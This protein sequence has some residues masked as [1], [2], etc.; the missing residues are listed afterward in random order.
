MVDWLVPQDRR[1]RIDA[2]PAGLSVRAT[3]ITLAVDA[4]MQRNGARVVR[5]VDEMAM[6]DAIEVLMTWV[7]DTQN[8]EIL[9]ADA[10]VDML[11]EMLLADSMTMSDSVTV[12]T[13]LDFDYYARPGELRPGASRFGTA[14]SASAGNFMN[15]NI[16]DTMGMA[17][18]AALTA[19]SFTQD[20]TMAMADDVAALG[21]I[22]TIADGMTSADEAISSSEDV[23]PQIDDTITM[24]DAVTMLALQDVADGMAMAETL[25]L[26]GTAAV[27]DGITAADALA[28]PSGS[29]TIADA[30]TAADA[31]ADV[32]GTMA[33]A[34]GIAA[35]D[36]VSYTSAEE[37]GGGGATTLILLH[38][39]EST[40]PTRPA[41]VVNSASG[42]P[43]MSNLGNGGG[44]I[45]TTAGIGPFGQGM[46]LLA[47]TS[48][49]ATLSTTATVTVPAGPW[50]WECFSTGFSDYTNPMQISSNGNPS[51]A[52]FFYAYID[53][54]GGGDVGLVIEGRIGGEDWP[55]E[56]VSSASF[57]PVSGT[58]GTHIAISR[59]ASDY[60][61]VRAN[62]NLLGTSADP[63]PGAFTNVYLDVAG[64]YDRV[65][66]SHNGTALTYVGEVRFRTGT[67]GYTGATYT[68]P[69]ARFT[70]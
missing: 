22:P 30:I 40:N 12:K 23:G 61:E 50:C 5:L 66:N 9:T 67:P 51:G 62:G 58:G 52:D 36:G 14:P 15:V 59:N 34:D 33:L 1:L 49:A 56:L 6:A 18:E 44:G 7:A 46:Q 42:G 65:G 39:N 16:A 25:D 19:M 13:L 17:D 38:L 70:G 3:A 24:S 32:Q 57:T 20:D 45:F 31:L 21:T 64:A 4:V 11:G 53:P 29:A 41:T 26:L 10:I 8:D 69:T 63:L 2:Q 47:G 60:I 54:R 28:D 35:A 68:V 43:A 37:G 48:G 55:P 27:A